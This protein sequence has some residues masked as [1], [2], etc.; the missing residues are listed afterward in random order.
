MNKK[1]ALTVAVIV[2]LPVMFNYLRW[3]LGLIGNAN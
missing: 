2:A 3:G 1:Q